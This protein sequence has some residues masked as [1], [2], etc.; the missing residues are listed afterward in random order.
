MLSELAI[1]PEMFC[2]RFYKCF[3]LLVK[4]FLENPK[5]FLSLTGQPHLC[6]SFLE[7]DP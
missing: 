1:D 3:V 5:D 6:D 4:S 7:G 2:L